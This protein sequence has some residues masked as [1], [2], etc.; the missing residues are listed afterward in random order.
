MDGSDYQQP[1]ASTGTR[2]G[3]LYRKCMEVILNSL[4]R[5]NLVVKRLNTRSPIQPVAPTTD[6]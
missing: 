6:T 5:Y 2:L 4:P 3:H 1:E